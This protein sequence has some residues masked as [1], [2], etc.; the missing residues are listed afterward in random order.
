M[1]T[2]AEQAWLDDICRIGCLVC[3]DLGYPSTP[4]VPHHLLR[5]GRRIGH[6]STICLCDPGHHQGSDGHLKISRHPY[7]ARFE[8]AYGTE[9]KL[10]ERQRELVAAVRAREAVAFA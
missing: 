8:K 10:L 9:A 4:G 3:Y 1:T 7:K 6:L 5:G 2:V